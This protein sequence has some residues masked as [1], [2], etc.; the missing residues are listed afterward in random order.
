MQVL[1]LQ[2]ATLQVLAGKAGS[3][4]AT[5]DSGQAPKG[6]PAVDPAPEPAAQPQAAAG[7]D[8]HAPPPAGEREGEAELRN[9]GRPA[10]R[11]EPPASQS[12]LVA[13]GA[14][15]GDAAFWEWAREDNGDAGSPADA[16]TASFLK[17]ARQ[18]PDQ[19][20]S[21][22][23][24][25]LATEQAGST[26]GPPHSGQAPE[27]RPAAASAT[28]AAIPRRDAAFDELP[29]TILALERE[30]GNEERSGGS[31]AQRAVPPGP[32]SMIVAD[33]AVVNNASFWEW[34]REDNGDAGS[35]ADAAAASFL[36]WARS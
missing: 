23:L 35:S 15:V 19:P 14:I 18:T 9:G 30:S 34:A 21:A 22:T 2:S 7:A 13:D 16:A 26:P 36:E 27:G 29:G 12:M 33:G 17:W 8:L 1:R 4:E 24:H 31:P 25:M 6:W 5:P 20:Q 10:Q 3:P 32:Q 28:E 11:A